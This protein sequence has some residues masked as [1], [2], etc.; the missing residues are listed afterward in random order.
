MAYDELWIAA[1]VEDG[2]N[3]GRD[4]GD[5]MNLLKPLLG[6]IVGAAF[7]L[8]PVMT[9]A[10]EK[11]ETPPI[12]VYEASELTLASYTVVKRIWTGTWWGSFIVPSHDELARAIESLKD[13]A[14]DVGADAVVNLNC[15]NDAAWDGRY[16]C[17][18]LAIKLKQ[19]PSFIEPNPD[20]QPAAGG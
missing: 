12:R 3:S 8:P 20:S 19:P 6:F 17:Y 1:A 15:L 7:A 10:Q 16:F 5:R 18:G 11:T 14:A 4:R 9:L 2:Y 13:K